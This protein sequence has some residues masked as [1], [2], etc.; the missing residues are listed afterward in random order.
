MIPCVKCVLPGASDGGGEPNTRSVG[1]T[2]PPPGPPPRP[3]AN[4]LTLDEFVEVELRMARALETL[5]AHQPVHRVL[6][7]GNVFRVDD[8]ENEVELE[9]LIE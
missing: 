2:A 1:P 7:L 5:H 9:H 4:S 3:S 8:V 6:K